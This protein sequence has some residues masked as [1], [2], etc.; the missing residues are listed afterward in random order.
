[1]WDQHNKFTGPYL[2]GHTNISEIEQGLDLLWRNGIAPHQVVFGFAFYVG[3][4]KHVDKAD[5]S[6]TVL[7]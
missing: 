4:T 3:E 7:Y 6:L 1:M 5:W 2:E